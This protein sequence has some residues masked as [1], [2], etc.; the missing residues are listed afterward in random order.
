MTT[1][2]KDADVQAAETARRLLEFLEKEHEKT[3]TSNG[4]IDTRI[5]GDI[6]GNDHEEQKTA[7]EGEKIVEEGIVEEIRKEIYEDQ[8]MLDTNH[9][10]GNTEHTFHV[11][12]K[13]VTK[14][15]GDSRFSDLEESMNWDLTRSQEAQRADTPMADVNPSQGIIINTHV[16]GG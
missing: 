7:E 14:A 9:L 13:I 4:T 10:E 12:E 16:N 15:D 11:D 6:T 3:L 1:A 5:M 8:K 2:D